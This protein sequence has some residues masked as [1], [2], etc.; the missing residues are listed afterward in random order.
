MNKFNPGQVV[1]TPGALAAFEASGESLF[2]YPT[3]HLSGDWGDVDA[4]N[5]QENERSLKHGWRLWSAYA[6]KSGVRIWTITEANR[7][8]TCVLLPE[9]Y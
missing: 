2:D 8:S 7:S 9:E 1:A 5:A 4:E 6:L 3:R